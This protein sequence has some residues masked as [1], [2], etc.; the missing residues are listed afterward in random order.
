MPSSSFMPPMYLKFQFQN[1]L[2]PST[3]ETTISYLVAPREDEKKQ[4]IDGDGDGVNMT[5]N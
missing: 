5:L 4:F 2:V 1:D 3:Y